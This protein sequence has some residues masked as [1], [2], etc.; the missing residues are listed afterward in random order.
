MITVKPMPDQFEFPPHHETARQT[1]G[2]GDPVTFTMPLWRKGGATF[3][4]EVTRAEPGH[5]AIGV[6]VHT[7]G[8]RAIVF[9]VPVRALRKAAKWEDTA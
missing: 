2:V 4:G 7:D 8:G 1:L 5:D 6:R 3:R 9:I